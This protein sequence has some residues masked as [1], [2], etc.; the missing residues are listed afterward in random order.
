MSN[1]GIYGGDWVEPGHDKER[2]RMYVYKCSNR[3]C[4]FTC[5]E[6]LVLKKEHRACWIEG[7]NG[8][9]R[10]VRDAKL[11]PKKKIDSRVVVKK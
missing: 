3:R 8:R 9:L 1:T 7:C 4:N 10:M 6:P 5:E 2:S 11:S